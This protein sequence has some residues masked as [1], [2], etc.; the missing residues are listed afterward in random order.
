MAAHGIDEA[1]RLAE[2]GRLDDDQHPRR[3]RVLDGPGQCH[4]DRRGVVD[5]T[6]ADVSAIQAAHQLDGGVVAAGQPK[7]AVGLRAIAMGTGLR[8][9][10]RRVG[11]ASVHFS[12][13]ILPRHDRQAGRK[14]SGRCATIGGGPFNRQ[15][16]PRF[17][18]GHGA[19]RFCYAERHMNLL[20]FNM[21]FADSAHPV[22][23]WLLCSAAVIII[24]LAKSGFGGGVGILAVPMFIYALDS[25]SKGIGT[26]LLLLIAA[27]SLSVVHH[28][29]TWDKHNLKCLLPGSILGIAIGSLIL[30]SFVMVDDTGAMRADSKSAERGLNLIIG[31]IA[32]AYPLLDR[33]K[34][35]YAAHWKIPANWITGSATGIIAGVASS[36]AHA[37]GPITSIYLLGQHLDKQRFMGT[38]VIYY[39]IVNNLKLIPYLLLG[40]IA[41]D[42]FTLQLMLLPLIPIGTFTGSRLHRVMS[43]RLFRNTILVLVFLT[44][45]Q[46]ITGF[47]PMKLF[48]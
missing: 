18:T 15:S 31:I 25:P 47:N 2:R 20:A 5:L 4:H 32:A 13:M 11:G 17:T 23:S 35:R 42:T 34:A 40:L 9:P 27:D 28:W 24:G 36:L 43:Q 37:A 6:D 29:G 46:M 10:G 16:F 38:S 3:G 33:I 41:T 26:L 14:S 19:E 44:G 48:E 30:A 21:P 22:L 1:L 39:F 45:V 7:Q 12:D 8:G